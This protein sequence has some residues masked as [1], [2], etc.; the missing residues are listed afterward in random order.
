[1]SHSSTWRNVCQSPIDRTCRVE[2]RLHLIEADWNAVALLEVG[3]EAIDPGEKI[4]GVGA[5]VERVAG[6]LDMDGVAVSA[7]S[8]ATRR[9]IVPARAADRD[10]SAALKLHFLFQHPFARVVR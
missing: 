1:S 2:L 4:F 9:G 8:H 7:E 6:H 3:V 5:G 10:P